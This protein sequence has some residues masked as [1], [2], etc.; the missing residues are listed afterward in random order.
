MEAWCSMDYDLYRHGRLLSERNYAKLWRR[1]RG[2]V[3]DLM[4]R[5]REERGLAVPPPGRRPSPKPRPRSNGGYL[6]AADYHQAISETE[7]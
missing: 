4:G 3:S 1:S 2:W 7:S 6:T 5:F